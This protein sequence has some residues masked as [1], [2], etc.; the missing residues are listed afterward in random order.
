MTQEYATEMMHEP[1][2]ANSASMHDQMC[3]CA[4]PTSTH[5]IKSK[6]TSP[7]IMHGDQNTD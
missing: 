5:N 7:M 2:F 1:F 4:S 3:D 6:R